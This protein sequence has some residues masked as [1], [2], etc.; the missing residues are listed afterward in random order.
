M[1]RKDQN[2]QRLP[3]QCNQRTQILPLELKYCTYEGDLVLARGGSMSIG[4]PI[5]ATWVGAGI[6]KR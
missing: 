3:H 6:F 1:T 5:T 4:D 2:K